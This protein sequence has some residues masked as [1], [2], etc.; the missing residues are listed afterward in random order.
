MDEIRG[1]AGEVSKFIFI[2][3]IKEG[4]FF[5]MFVFNLHMCPVSPGSD[6]K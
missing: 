3:L 1:V 4:L 2:H 6:C 5:L